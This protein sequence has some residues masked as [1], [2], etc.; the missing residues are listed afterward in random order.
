MRSRN[1]IAKAAKRIR[2]KVVMD[3]R[4]KAQE[5]LLD[6]LSAWDE[7]WDDTASKINEIEDGT[8]K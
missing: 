2:P 5:S 7:Y 8:T 4:V 3:K 1:P 6:G